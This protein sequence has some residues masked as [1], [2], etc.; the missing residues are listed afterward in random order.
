M[1]H[2]EVSIHEVRI[3]VA[4]RDSANRWLTNKEIA[5]N[6]KVAYRTTAQH[7]QRLV[8]LGLLDVAEVFPAH[9]YRLAQKA[10]KRNAAYVLKLERALEVFG[11]SD[12]GK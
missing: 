6:A 3:F 7:T 5:G 12:G 8:K 4:L 11:I 2:N 9:R 10:A 1:E